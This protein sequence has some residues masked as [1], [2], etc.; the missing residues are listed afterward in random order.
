MSPSVQHRWPSRESCDYTGS[1]VNPLLAKNPC[2]IVFH[3]A[4]VRSI[5]YY[6]VSSIFSSTGSGDLSQ[7]DKMSP[8]ALDGISVGLLQNFRCGQEFS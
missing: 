2:G 5:I 3:A 7:K 8:T 4:N 6:F 1:I